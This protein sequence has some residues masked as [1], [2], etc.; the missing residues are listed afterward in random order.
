MRNVSD[1]SCREYQNT[2]F[3]LSN[4]FLE[5][6]AIY[7]IMGKNI[8]ERGRPQMSI[9]HMFIDAGYL[10]LCFSAEIVV[11]R[12]CLNVTLYVQYL[13]FYYTELDAFFPHPPSVCKIYSN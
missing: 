9:W 11:A 6:C 1:K 7:E 3:V 5:N 8:L 13:S 2:H 12:M 4:F 10:R